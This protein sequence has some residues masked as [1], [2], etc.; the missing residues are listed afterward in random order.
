M[1]NGVVKMRNQRKLVVEEIPWQDAI[2]A[3]YNGI[4]AIDTLGRIVIFNGA[5]KRILGLGDRCVLN[6]HMRE[7]VPELWPD[8]REALDEGLPQIG[9]RLNVGSLSLIANRTPIVL[10]N[11]LVGLVSVFQDTSELEKVATQL[12][13]VKQLVSQLDAIIESS[14]DGLYITDGQGDTLRVNRSFE[15]ITGIIA[16]DL[17][18]R[19]LIDLEREGYI[20]ES[21]TLHVLQTGKAVTLRSRTKT[22]RDLLCTGN[23]IFEDTG[24]ISMVVTNVRDMTDLSQLS[25]QLIKS[26]RITEEYELKLEKIKIQQQD[27]SGI[28]ARSKEMIDVVDLALRVAAVDTP[29]LLQGETGVGKE[30]VARLIHGRSGRSDKGIFMKINCGTIPENLLES[31]LFG[32]EGGAFTGASQSGKKGLFELAENGTLFLDEIEALSLNLQAKLLSVLQDLEIMRVGGVKSKKIN[33]RIIAASNRDLY[34]MVKDKTFREDLFFRLNVVPIY[35]PALR[36]RK[37]DILPLVNHYLEKYNTKYK[38]T[39]RLSRSVIDCLIEYPWFGN[40]RELSNVIE[41]LVVT[42]RAN[43]LVLDDLPPEMQTFR[44]NVPDLDISRIKSLKQAVGQFEYHLIQEAV[45]LCGNAK[46]AATFLKIDPAT[47]TRKVQRYDLL[48]KCK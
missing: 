16:S 32:Y 25:R 21:A 22:G 20:S 15:K 5:A 26:K 8:L 11:R 23:P 37:D 4:I 7:I 2:D 24:K 27:G 29:V 45:R 40:V 36:K 19:N 17:I 18:G 34:E 46:K 10:E 43:D 6:R 28:V 41:R 35:V 3:A 9:K 30:V 38:T 14:Y 12:S 31:E 13:S 33:T 44:G 1:S 39:K 42:S 48:Q 47:V